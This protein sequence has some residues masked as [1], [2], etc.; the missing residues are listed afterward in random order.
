MSNKNNKK[1]SI[2]K[3]K[4]FLTLYGIPC[5]FWILL[6]LI[7]MTDKSTQASLTWIGFFI[8]NII[9]FIIWFLISFFIAFLHSKKQT[10]D[11][12]MGRTPER[13]WQ[14]TTTFKKIRF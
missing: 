14:E 11:I 13:K 7:A 8:E 5:W 2:L 12:K 10:K 9:V 3:S 6:S 1:K 4:F